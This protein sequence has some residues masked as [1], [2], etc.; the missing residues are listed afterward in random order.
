[1]TIIPGTTIRY[2]SGWVTRI[3]QELDDVSGGAFST[4]SEAQIDAALFERF[5]LARTADS[6]DCS[7][8]THLARYVNTKP[9]GPLLGNRSSGQDL[10]QLG[11]SD[12]M[13]GSMFKRE[14]RKPIFV[15]VESCI[16][17]FLITTTTISADVT[18]DI[19]L[20]TMRSR[21]LIR[22]TNT[23]GSISTAFYVTGAKIYMTSYRI[24]GL[25]SPRL[26]S[27]S[28]EFSWLEVTSEN[29]VFLGGVDRKRVGRLLSHRLI[30][31]T[32]INEHLLATNRLVEALTRRLANGGADALRVY[33]E[34]SRLISNRGLKFQPI[35]ITLSEFQTELA[36]LSV[37]ES[38]ST[39]VQPPAIDTTCRPQSEGS[40]I[41][42]SSD[43][44]LDLDTLSVSDA[45]R[46]ALSDD[47]WNNDFK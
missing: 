10:L 35:R 15:E 21:L 9:R 4:L 46:D 2:D 40:I 32:V 38:E 37:D 5:L 31:N 30:A 45:K 1:M 47:S 20:G 12:V 44:M 6:L 43:D 24:R 17:G 27:S 16:P 41:S 8:Y 18:V 22:R 36:R 39:A 7:S 14:F 25:E 33:D 13:R 28:P 26:L 42:I 23:Q 19:L 34:L 11:R 3:R 29:C